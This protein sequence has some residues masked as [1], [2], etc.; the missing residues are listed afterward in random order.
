MKAPEELR[1]EFVHQWLFKA[2]EDLAAA[3]HLLSSAPVLAGPAGFHAKQSAEKYLKA[4]LVWQGIE[5]TKTHNI[6]NLLDLISTSDKS[7]AASLDA[8][9]VLTR[10]AVYSRSPADIREI[11]PQEAREAVKLAQEAKERIVAALEDAL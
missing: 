3:W 4:Y 8:A 5:F 2:E 9:S 10:Y 1:R 11:S 6:A 7:L